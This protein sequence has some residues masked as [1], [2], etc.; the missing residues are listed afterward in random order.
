MKKFIFLYGPP[1]VGKSRCGERLANALDMPFIDLDIHIENAVGMDIQTI[2]DTKGQEYFREIESSAL[3]SVING[4]AHVVSLGGGA[5][6]NP[7]N[8]KE[9]EEHG[10]IICLNASLEILRKRLSKGGES[11][12]P[13]LKDQKLSELLESRQKHY[14]SFPLQIKTDSLSPTQ[15]VGEIQILLG[16]FRVSSTTP[17]TNVIIGNGLLS[18]LG[19]I[20]H[21]SPLTPPFIVI[22]DSNV[23]DHYA[24]PALK[25]LRQSGYDPCKIIFQA[26]EKSKTLEVASKIWA[27]MLDAKIERSGT[28]LALGGGVTSDLAGFAAATYMRGI[29][30]GSI[31][32]SL[33]AMVDASLGGK[34]GVNLP[35]GKNLV[36]AFHPPH[37]VIIDPTLLKTLPEIEIKNGMA[38]VVKQ[39]VIGDPRL[40]EMCA[41]SFPQ[42]VKD[43]INVVKRAVSVKIK[44]IQADPFEQNIRATLNFGH[45]VGHAVE[46]LSEYKIRHGEAVAIGMIVETRLA[47]HLGIAPKGLAARIAGVLTSLGLPID[48]P[49][50]F[51]SNELI[52]I[53]QYDKK[54]HGGKLRF[55]L[56]VDVGQVIHDIE[57]E[58]LPELMDEIGG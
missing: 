13:L 35:E 23:A 7:T 8:C 58:D 3:N 37:L 36:G 2:F 9:A 40:F 5:L 30:W 45:T 10:Q 57:I 26:G 54:H 1:G 55:A 21:P 34:T 39:A 14:A 6:L 24:T 56:P 19:E 42:I 31:P 51:I 48:I 12:R 44:M 52:K 32:S 11:E 43:W 25:E 29:S 47:E 17:E 49:S 18:C 15:I 16:V 4:K 22:C 33:L 38:E 20:I 50:N 46:A 41:Q 28:V 27:D 53:M